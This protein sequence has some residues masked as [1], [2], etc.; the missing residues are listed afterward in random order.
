MGDWVGHWVRHL[1]VALSKDGFLT[2][3]W[4]VRPDAG[5]WK[6]LKVCQAARLAGGFKGEMLLSCP[7]PKVVHRQAVGLIYTVL[8]HEPWRPRSLHVGPGASPPDT[9]VFDVR[10]M[11]PDVPHAIAIVGGLSHCP[12][13][14]LRD[15][16]A[17]GPKANQ[18]LV[19]HSSV[20]DSRR[21]WWA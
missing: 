21:A 9:A 2:R 7:L 11:G 10:R 12:M 4:N 17:P 14:L 5:L 18:T 3:E 13:K 1:W 6:M 16:V 20:Q 15:A 8:T 19:W